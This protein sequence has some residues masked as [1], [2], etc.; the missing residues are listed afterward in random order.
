MPPPRFLDLAPG[1]DAV[2]SHRMGADP[3]GAG[4]GEDPEARR[5]VRLVGRQ[6]DETGALKDTYLD[7]R[8]FLTALWD[9]G[10][11]HEAPAFERRGYALLAQGGRRIWARNGPA[12]IENPAAARTGVVQLVALT[13]H[14]DKGAPLGTLLEASRTNYV[15]QSAFKN[16]T[17]TGWTVSGS[18]TQSAETNDLLWDASVV[19]RV[20]K[21]VAGNP[22][23]TEFQE[24]GA[25]TS[26]ITANS[27]VRMSVYFKDL[28]GVGIYVALQ[29]AV[30][31][32]WWRESDSTWQ[33]AKTWNQVTTSAAWARWVSKSIAIGGSGTTLTPFFGVPTTGVAGQSH[34]VGHVQLEVGN[35]ATSPILTEA[36]AVTRAADSAYYDNNHGKR[37]WP[38][39]ALTARM[40]YVPL[41]STSELPAGAVRVLLDSSY[42]ADNYDRLFY[43]QASASIVFRRRRRATN[44][45]ATK[46]VTLTAGQLARFGLRACSSRGEWGL[47][48]YTLSV[49]AEGVKG[50]DAIAAGVHALPSKHSFRV[51]HRDN[52]GTPADVMDGYF[53]D[54]EV[55]NL[56]MHDGEMLA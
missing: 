9:P 40:G 26:S 1:D 37:V 3:S 47:S 39:E 13:A 50:T 42:D 20:C 45:D 46:A 21:L 52:A 49:L 30:D 2:I 51:G 5:H 54:L 23:T 6:V 44:T 10:I 32:N 38:A 8:R 31:S 56:V 4:W 29:R 17:F 35:Y 22:I 55:W 43:D 19:P 27:L 28:L 7:T 11:S 24:Q 48:P 53:K 16:G 14:Q 36:T 33:A 18:G 12:Y 15:I 34:L 41:F 25:A